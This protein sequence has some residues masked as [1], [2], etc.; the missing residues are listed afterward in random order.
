[1]Q[2]RCSIIA[3]CNAK[4]DASFERGQPITSNVALASPLLS[5]FD[6]IL[7]ITDKRQSSWD[8]A[9]SSSILDAA[10]GKSNNGQGKHNGTW[11]DNKNRQQNNISFNSHLMRD[12]QTI[13]MMGML[14]EHDVLKAYVNHVRTESH[15]SLSPAA[16]VILAKYYQLQRKADGRDAAR[17][18][19][20]L[21]ESLIR[22]AQAHAKLMGRDTH[23]Q[24]NDSDNDATEFKD[25][26]QV[27]VEDA[28]WAI[29]LME[30]SLCTTQSMF[31]WNNKIDLYATAPGL[32]YYSINDTYDEDAVVAESD[33]NNNIDKTPSQLAMEQY[34]E[35]EGSIMRKLEINLK[36]FENLEDQVLDLGIVKD[37]DEKNSTQKRFNN[38]NGNVAIKNNIAS[39]LDYLEDF[40]E[41]AERILCSW[42][43]TQTQRN[44]R[45]EGNV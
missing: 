41:E 40:D 34:E 28:V 19:I 21:L 1:M 43:V 15:P 16:R 2:T 44:V 39:T 17:T 42:S 31:G 12:H 7:V 30:A 22:L 25:A 8:R 14:I 3:A 38:G 35:Y 18:T 33:K 5:R 37:I 36:V 13:E 23:I 6:L 11:M 4:G 45:Y 10:I 29:V 9:L 27:Q 20:R 32:D 26:S 24:T